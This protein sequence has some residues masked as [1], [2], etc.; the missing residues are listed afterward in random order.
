M[1]IVQSNGVALTLLRHVNTYDFVYHIGDVGYAD[2]YFL[3]LSS[4]DKVYSDYMDEIEP[5]ASQKAYMALPGNHEASCNEVLPI[6]CPE[7]QKNFTAWRS[8]W[9]MPTQ[10][11]KGVQNMWYSFDYGLVHFVQISTETDFPGAPEGPNTWIPSGPFG[12]QLS[13][14]A[15]DLERAV[16]NRANVPWIVVAGHRPIWFTGGSNAAVHNA[17]LPLLLKFN[18]DFFLAGHE[19]CYERYWPIDSSGRAPQK[20]Y[21]NPMNTIYLINGQGGNAEGHEGGSTVTDYLAFR[22]T[23]QF[24][25]SRFNVYNS[26][27]LS[28]EFI[29]EQDTILD[30]AVV[31][32]SR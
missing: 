20:N 8:R 25:W 10:E 28:W 5:F 17:F 7:R 22:Q 15:A 31:Y 1:G 14:L 18:V 24:G 13:W 29:G 16:A 27:V 32:K 4:Y 19:H 11:S 12:D 6:A 9:A 26:S 3:Y 21:D 2:D 23:T 30:R